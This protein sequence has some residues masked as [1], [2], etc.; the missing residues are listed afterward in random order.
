MS[1]LTGSPAI[2]LARRAWSQARGHRRRMVLYVSMFLV[3]QAFSFAQPYVIGRLLNAVQL[4]GTSAGLLR[5]VYVFAAAYFGIELGFW[6]FHAPARCIERSVAFEVRAGYKSTLFYQGTQ[7]PLQWHRD[8]HSGDSID[9]I[10]RAANA[11]YDFIANSF[12]VIY[13][14]LRLFG[15]QLILCLFMPFAGVMA[16][17]TTLIVFALIFRFDRALGHQY[18]DLNAM[19]NHVATALHD[20]FTNMITVITLRLEG[21]VWAEVKRRIA[22]PLSL[23]ERNTRLGEAKWFT[24]N[25]LITTMIVVVLVVHARGQVVAG[26][27]VMGGTLFTLFEYLR[28]IGDAF[29]SFAG[30]YGTL[31]RQAA[32]VR[33]AEP[34][35]AAFRALARTERSTALPA[36]WKQVRVADLKFKYRDDARAASLDGVTVD[37]PRGKSIAVVGPSGSGKST[38][39]TLLRGLQPPQ[40]ATYTCDGAPLALADLAACTTLMPQEPEIFSDTIRFN[41]TFGM[42]ATDEEILAAIRAARFDGVLERLPGGLETHLVEK[43]VNLSG[44]EKQRLALARGVFFSRASEIVLMDEPTSSVDTPNEKAIY[45]NLLE[46]YRDRCM[47]SSIHKLHLLPLFDH[48]YVFEAGRLV[49]D[50]SFQ[51][52]VARQGVLARMWEAYQA[53]AED[54]PLLKTA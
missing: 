52:L 43:G 40:A 50:G 14:V 51:A 15:A 49:E 24:T 1:F 11:L 20:Y 8:N 35:E 41:I 13:M 46:L 47:V 29:Y 10:N 17:V 54:E 4:N 23:Y 32:D 25:T 16:L 6:L 31:G 38:L 44:G 26:G 21:R 36:G 37:L 12:S 18:D 7:L 9:R 34:L 27:V 30:L 19:E 22:I 48:V 53:A 42:E 28:R 33:G 3:A 45:T 39:L 5:E 2:Y